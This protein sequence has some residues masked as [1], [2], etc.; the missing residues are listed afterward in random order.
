MNGFT[1]SRREVLAGV[2]GALA[3]GGGALQVRASEA[4][5]SQGGALEIIVPAAAGGGFDTVARQSQHALRQ[6]GLAQ[7]IEV[8]N[9]PGGGGT[10]GLSH[11]AQQS[12]RSDLLMVMGLSIVGGVQ[13][14]GS[15]TTLDDITP[16]AKLAEDY[17]VVTVRSDS[18]ITSFDQLAQRWRS[19]PREV[20]VAGGAVG[21][22]DHLLVA[23]ALQRLGA[24]PADLNYLVYSGDGEVL[25]S[26]LSRTADVAVSS[27]NGF[28]AQLEAGEVRAL[29]ISSPE[30]LPGIEIPTVRES[31]LDLDLANWRGFAAPPGLSQQ[32][33]T[34]LE[35]LV[36][37][38]VETP[39]WR[40]AL[41]R[42]GWKDAFLMGSDFETFL[43]EEKK[44]L[45]E[46]IEGLGLA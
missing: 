30:R 12:G 6:N 7:A 15:S 21:N 43:A 8:T 18:P 38:L 3:L 19:N 22:A 29:A 46:I 14:T 28:A 31:G 32:Q 26:L 23:M 41:Q 33:R 13:I 40:Q 24:D 27:Y 34:T 20:V 5:R 16:L 10:L 39:E 11:V 36:R 42:F 25:T 4:S 2:I 37:N 1:P 44:R 45:T 9:M 17:I 35:Q